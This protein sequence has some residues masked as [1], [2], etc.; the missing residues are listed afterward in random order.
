MQHFIQ[1]SSLKLNF[2][3]VDF[4]LVDGATD[5]IFI[6]C[7]V[8]RNLEYNGTVIHQIFMEFKKP[9]IQLKENCPAIFS[10]NSVCEPIYGFTALV[11]LSRLF[12]FLIYTQLV[13]LLGRG[14][15]PWQGRYRHNALHGAAT[16]I[17]C[18]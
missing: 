6:V 11:D 4:D 15:S 9:V 16:L 10:L 17:C 8:L 2:F 5:K 1:H 12:S 7:K 3:S 14:I 18:M 13:G